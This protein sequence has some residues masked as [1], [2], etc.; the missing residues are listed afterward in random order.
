MTEY[1]NIIKGSV[2]IILMYRCIQL[3]HALRTNARPG[4]REICDS[5]GEI[6]TI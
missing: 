2:V 1:R 5:K 4:R 3:W 6:R